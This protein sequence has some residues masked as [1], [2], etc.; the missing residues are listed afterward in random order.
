MC[1]KPTPDFR[2]VGFLVDV[3]KYI[4]STK[5]VNKGVVVLEDN[6]PVTA[7][8]GTKTPEVTATWFAT[9]S[10]SPILEI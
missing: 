1:V 8:A 2:G 7:L 6:A 3:N 4:R 10:F 5:K 9:C